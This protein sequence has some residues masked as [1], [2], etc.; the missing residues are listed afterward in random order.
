MCWTDST[1]S[2]PQVLWLARNYRAAAQKKRAKT[3]T[4]N[5]SSVTI[6]H[7]HT[8]HP[9]FSKY[10]RISWRAAFGSR[11]WP[12]S[13]PTADTWWLVSLWL[14][15]NM[16]SPFTIL[17]VMPSVSSPREAG[18]TTLR[19][20]YKQDWAH[21]LTPYLSGESQIVHSVLNSNKA[22]DY[23][24]L[25]QEIMVRCGWSPTDTSPEF[26]KWTYCSG[27]P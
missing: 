26:F 9:E 15:K 16:L 3:S 1:T 6:F 21:I 7:P 23:K 27:N 13:C 19:P 18:T 20:I 25:K 11:W 17:P 24:N 4:A 12:R 8:P 22:E 2:A 10:C 5:R 14:L